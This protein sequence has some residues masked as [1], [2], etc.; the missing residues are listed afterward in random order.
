MEQLREIHPNEAAN[1]NNQKRDELLADEPLADETLP[2]LEQQLE[3]A[4][5][6]LHSTQGPSPLNVENVQET[7]DTPSS[8]P[9]G[10]GAHRPPTLQNN[11]GGKVENNNGES[12][13][14]AK[15]SFLI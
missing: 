14:K 1:F 11:D 8:E 15:V 6:E 10:M 9:K 3:S 13:P 2:E 4:K 7:P 12:K 5:P